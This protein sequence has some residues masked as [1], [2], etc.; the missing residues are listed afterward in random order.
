MLA[1][2]DLLFIDIQLLDVEY[3]FLLQTTLV[4]FGLELSKA[5]QNFF[6]D[7]LHAFLLEFFDLL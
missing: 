3:H 4:R 1:E 6:S 2:T 7:S 5:A